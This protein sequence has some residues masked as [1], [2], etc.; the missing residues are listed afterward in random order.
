M[1]HHSEK[2]VYKQSKHEIGYNIN[3]ILGI[4]YRD[5]HPTWGTADTK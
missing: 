2:N 4:F 1:L 5:D 3:V